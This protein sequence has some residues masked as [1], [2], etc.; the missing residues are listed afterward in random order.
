MSEGIAIAPFW[1]D[2][3]NGLKVKLAVFAGE[4]GRGYNFKF[5]WDPPNPEKTRTA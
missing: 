1:R 2:E 3:S 4:G 5:R